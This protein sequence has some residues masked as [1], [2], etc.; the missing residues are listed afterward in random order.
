MP[1]HYETLGVSKDATEKEIK[2]AFRAMSMKYHP[3]KVQS[4][5]PEEQDEANR[6][7]QEINS[8]NDVLSDPQQRQQYDIELQGGPA[9]G[10]P[11]GFPFNPFGQGNNPFG[12]GNNPFGQGFP[13]GPGVHFAHSGG[14]PNIHF[15]HS[16]GGPNIHFAHGPLNGQNIFEMLFGEMHGFERRANKPEPIE[17][18]VEISL[19]NAYDGTPHEIEIERVV[20]TP[21]S[22]TKEKETLIVNIPQGVDNG[23]S[24]VIQDK[25][26]VIMG[27]TGD[28]KL[29]IRI[30]NDTEFKR[31]D[32]DL[33]YKKKI[34]LKEALCGF[35]FKLDHISGNQISLNVNVV[36]F[37]GAKQ[38]IKNWGMIKNGAVG[39]FVLEFEVVFPDSLTDEQKTALES[40]L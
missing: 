11:P 9:Q 34:S 19:K 27:T 40:I 1:T 16:G 2:Q 26:H 35:K 39:N 3:D 23:D 5:S 38:V 36:I 8:A 15:A 32:I 20:K 12:Q 25:G 24:V 29:N 14:G 18:D 17:K 21:N 22:M 28:V 30:T 7:M 13:F 4:K 33:H 10:F 31:H 6:K 37:T